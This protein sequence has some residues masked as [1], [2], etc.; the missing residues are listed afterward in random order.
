[1][2]NELL[3]GR[4]AKPLQDPEDTLTDVTQIIHNF[5]ILKNEVLHGSHHD[6]EGP[7]VQLLGVN[8]H[9]SAKKPAAKCTGTTKV[10]LASRAVVAS[11]AE[12]ETCAVDPC[13]ARKASNLCWKSVALPTIVEPVSS[14]A[15]QIQHMTLPAALLTLDSP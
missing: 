15:Q 2:H 3:L 10:F 11:C 4:T 1:M 14:S 6:G 12:M 9:D 8:L 5:L 13:L 7:H